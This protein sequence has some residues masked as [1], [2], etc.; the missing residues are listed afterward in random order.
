MNK[1]IPLCCMAEG[2]SGTVQRILLSGA[3]RRRLQDLGLME[4]APIQCCKKAPGGSPI[5]YCFCG[6]LV[7]LRDKDAC[8]ILVC[9][10]GCA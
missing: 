3:M 6:T 5:A 10:E 4:G 1:W 9:P 7:A 2:E 8:A